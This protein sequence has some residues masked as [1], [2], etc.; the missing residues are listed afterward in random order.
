MACVALQGRTRHASGNRKGRATKKTVMDKNDLMELEESNRKLYSS[1]KA[2]QIAAEESGSLVFTYDTEKQTIFVDERTAEAFG[3]AVEQSGVPYEMV[4]RGVVSQDT[5]QEYLRIHE[6]ILNGAHEAGGI[7][8]L[9][10][11]DGSESIQELKFRAILD[12][13]GQLTGTAVGIYRDISERYIRDREQNRYRQAVYSSERLTFQYEA[14][15]DR[16]TIFSPP[17][18]SGGAEVMYHLDHFSDRMEAGEIGPEGDTFILQELLTKGAKKPVQVQLYSAKTKEL[19]W[20]GLTAKVVEEPGRGRQVF[21]VISD[22]TD[23]KAKEERYQKLDRVLQAIKNEHIGIFEIDLEQDTFTTLHYESQDVVSLPEQGPYSQTMAKVIPMLAAPEFQEQFLQFAS[24]DSLRTLLSREQRVEYEYMTGFEGQPWRRS[25]YQVVESRD[26]VPA[27][28]IMYQSDIDQIKTEKLR[29]QQAIQEAY[30]YAESAN[31]AKTDFLSRMSHD[32]RTPMN[33]IIGMTAIAGT[34]LERPERVRECLGKI[35]TASKHLLSLINEVLDMSK[36][37]SGAMELQEGVFNL[38]D[39]VDNM[40]AMVL[41]QIREHGHELQVS[42]GSLKHEWVVGD[43]L[44]IQQAFVNLISNAVKY[45][46]DGGTIHVSI[47]ERPSPSQNYG[48][49]EFCFEDNGIGM[50]EEFQKVLFEPFTRAEDSRLSKV[51]GTG[52]G[53]TITRNLIR[54]MDGEIHVDSRLNE[55]SRFT[56]T[57]HLKIQED[58]VELPKELLE[59]PALVVD[60][61]KDACES[62]CLLLNDIGMVGE[63]CLSGREAV[64]RVQNRCGNGADYFAVILDWKMPDMDGIATARAIRAAVGRDLPILFLTAYDWSEIEADARAAGVDKFLA[65]PLFRSRLVN[66][67]REL[68]EPESERTAEIAVFQGELAFPDKRVLLVEDNELNAE[69]ATELL[70]LTQIQVEWARDGSEAVRMVEESAEGY[71]DLV[72]M[73]VQMPVLDGYG[74]T[75]AI[76]GMDREDTKRL[77]IV[78]MTAN[79]FTEDINHAISAG[80]NEHIAKPVDMPQLEQVLIKYL[81]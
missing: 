48:E 2:F 41:P 6:A 25:T 27:K 39:L 55:G 59:L 58:G 64:E 14:E 34:N 70:R 80:M 13:N 81:S 10:Q 35:S 23:G 76:R 19:R 65:K 77:P 26:G 5:Q 38:A 74:A 69:I 49:Y 56:V 21:G 28:V 15:T 9:I 75:A 54:M 53:M 1:M 79:T 16:L 43:S 67:F 37:E 4:H 71:Y 33:A 20:Y 45:T 73:D 63:G 50:S 11:A 3:V 22:L 68:L 32:I 31:A 7:V 42:V 46:P 29:Q 78:A 24:A 36:I 57:I 30:Q 51:T 62:A 52:L 47:Q 12:E 17:S 44:R 61:D 66:S 72:F 8:K 18:E 60:D 40:I